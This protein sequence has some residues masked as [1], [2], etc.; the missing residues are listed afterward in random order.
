MTSPVRAHPLGDSAI[1]LSL[2]ASRSRELLS[3]VHELSRALAELRL[4]HVCDIVPS[5]LAV[6]VFYDSLSIPYEDMKEKLLSASASVANAATAHGEARQ[7]EIAVRY[8]GQD[9]SEVAER[10]SMSVEDVIHTHSS[11]TYTVDLLG[12]VP[13]FAYMS[14]VAASLQLPRRAEPRPRVAAG[15]VAIAGS[16]TGIYPLDTPGGWHLLGRTEVSLF[17]PTRSPPA[18]LKPGDSVR[19]V[20]A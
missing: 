18:L 1:T 19:F 16:H 8:D 12:F 9:L 11:R 13:G 5:Y 3:S 15:S 7:H 6:T 20:P 2:G 14:E 4:E 10:A 17:D